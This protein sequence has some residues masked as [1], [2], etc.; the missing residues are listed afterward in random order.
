MLLNQIFF[1]QDAWTEL[2]EAVNF[3]NAKTKGLGRQFLNAVERGINIICD[4]PN[5]FPLHEDTQTRVY[6]LQRLP[7]LIHF[8]CLNGSPSIMH[9][10]EEIWI[11][12][13]DKIG[14]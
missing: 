11:I 4:S 3:Y 13:I 6:S 9:S 12:G 8:I 2:L 5:S 10:N 14:L 1:Y 7:Y